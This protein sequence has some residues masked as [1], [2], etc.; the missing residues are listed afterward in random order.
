MVMADEGG[1]EDSVLAV[2]EARPARPS[3]GSVRDV[4]RD[5]FRV[6]FCDDGLGVA[7]G[8]RAVPFSSSPGCSWP[9]SSASSACSA[10]CGADGC[11]AVDADEVITMLRLD[12]LPCRLGRGAVCADDVA[13]S[14]P[15]CVPVA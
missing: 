1:A 2:D 5:R 10:S 4:V 6:R 3:V 12:V 11:G 13:T 15:P 8:G 14:C 9:A 7:S